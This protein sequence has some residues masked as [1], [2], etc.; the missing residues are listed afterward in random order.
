M[1][2]RLGTESVKFEVSPG[3]QT[4]ANWISSVYI[5]TTSN[6][7]PSSYFIKCL[8]ACEARRRAMESDAFSSN[9]VQFCGRVLEECIKFQEQKCVTSPFCSVTTIYN[10]YEGHNC[11]E[12]YESTWIYNAGQDTTTG[13]AAHLSGALGNGPL[14]R[15]LVRRQRSETS[16]VCRFEILNKRSCVHVICH[17]SLENHP[18]NRLGTSFKNPEEDTHKIG[19]RNNRSTSWNCLAQNV[20]AHTNKILFHYPPWVKLTHLRT[21][22]QMSR[23]G[24]IPSSLVLLT[25]KLRRRSRTQLP[26]PTKSLPR[27]S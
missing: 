6:Q 1:A 22:F 26:T 27:R 24:S 18:Y 15:L 8:P 20:D 21:Y 19:A 11:N 12:R 23:H 13:H 9:E 16:K 14:P 7:R 5:I 25:H 3:G 2:A 10:I 4:G 17:R